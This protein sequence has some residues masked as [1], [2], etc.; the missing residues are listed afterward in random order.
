MKAARRIS[1][2]IAESLHDK[3]SGKQAEDTALAFIRS[4]YPEAAPSSRE[5]FMGADFNAG[6]TCVEVAVSLTNYT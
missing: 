6:K 3:D 4:L 2:T 5:F 1:L